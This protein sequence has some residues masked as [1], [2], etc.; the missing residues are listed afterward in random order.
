[1]SQQQFLLE[2]R[3]QLYCQRQ[4]G[5]HIVEYWEMVMDKQEKKVQLIKEIIGN[6]KYYL[7]NYVSSLKNEVTPE[8]LSSLSDILQKNTE[9][10]YV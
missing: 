5:T 7:G 6:K 3:K 1:M 9:N 4:L 10:K 2:A 8:Y